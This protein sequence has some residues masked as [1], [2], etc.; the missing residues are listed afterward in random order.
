M[1]K[2]I[3]RYI[4]NLTIKRGIK[5]LHFIYNR[6]KKLAATQRALIQGCHSGYALTNL[7]AFFFIKYINIKK[8]VDLRN[9]Y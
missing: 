5:D 6:Y 9:F 2:K 3:K 1:R 7:T 4:R 8:K